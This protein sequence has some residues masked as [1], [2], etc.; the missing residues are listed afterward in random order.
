M[1]APVLGHIPRFDSDPHGRVLSLVSPFSAVAEA[2]RVLNANVRFLLAAHSH[3]GPMRR[4]ARPA[5]TGSV[6]IAS[7]APGEG[8]SS[9]AANLAVTAAR[10]GARVVLVEADLRNPAI[11]GLFGLDAQSGLSDLLIDA[12]DTTD[13]LVE[14]GVDN[15]VLLPAGSIPPNPAE[16]LASGQ[17]HALWAELRSMADLVIVDT[18]PLLRVA[19]GLEVAAH[20]DA[21]VVVARY[22]VTRTHELESVARRLGQIGGERSVG[23]VV[24]AEPSSKQDQPYGYGYGQR[25]TVEV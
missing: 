20:V 14:S 2:C 9:L 15:L 23:V 7:A 8:K 16:L 24:N 11:A 4:G 17:A 19:D 5:P 10:A 3:D 13:Y 25:P 21:V 18:P 12:G 1:D 6:M 22:G